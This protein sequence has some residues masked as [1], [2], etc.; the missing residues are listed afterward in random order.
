[1]ILRVPYYYDKFSCIADWCQHSCCVGWEI[2]IDEDT[3][4][5][6][7]SVPG[8]FGERLKQN[9]AE[10]ED[11][12]FVLKNERC[13]FLN[14]KNLCDICIELGEESL[15]EVCTEYPRFTITY[16][17]TIEK[18]MGISCEEVGRLVFSDDTLFFTIENEIE[19][20]YDMEEYQ[21]DHEEDLQGQ[22]GNEA[23]I[24]QEKEIWEYIKEARDYAISVLQRRDIALEER[25][26]DYL[27][28]AKNVQE[29]LNKNEPRRIEQLVAGRKKEKENSIE[30]LKEAVMGDAH[31]D[32]MEALQER[33]TV[34]ES[35]EVLDEEWPKALAHVKEV[36]LLSGMAEKDY[37]DLQREFSEY[38]K[39]RA[40]EWEQL[41]IYFTFRHFMKSVYDYRFFSQAQFAV[42][43]FLMIRDMDVVRFLDRGR[44]YST[45]D[46]VDVA[47][48][49]SKEVEHSED[50][51]EL[52]A[53]D[54][55]FE[56]VFSLEALCRQIL[57]N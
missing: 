34:F 1:M 38:Y 14:E 22:P 9:M 6:Y 31:F 29:Q 39:R 11:N 55:D 53:E 35:L 28:F 49:Y 25:L 32:R 5:Y 30:N 7:K 24:A 16:G 46:R 8:V 56:E 41:L 54:F 27:D 36:L 44:C 19:D 51:L 45:E 13:P 50:N 10:G 47:R 48:I 33:I 4:D 42:V 37:I 12:T 21:E 43:S 15:C 18:C 26:V 3:V 57:F 17:N 23:D 52:L 2:D 40:Y 20:V